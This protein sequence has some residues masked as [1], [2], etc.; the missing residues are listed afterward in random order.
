MYV[1]ARESFGLLTVRKVGECKKDCGQGEFSRLQSFFHFDIYG[2]MCHK[3]SVCCKNK[4]T[5]WKQ[6][7]HIK[8]HLYKSVECS[9]LQMLYLNI[10]QLGSQIISSAAPS[11]RPSSRSPHNVPHSKRRTQR[12]RPLTLFRIRREYCR[13]C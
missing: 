8:K 1:T 10:D 11:A 2:A 4:G 7:L 6:T 5:F 9:F 13:L 12:H 3:N